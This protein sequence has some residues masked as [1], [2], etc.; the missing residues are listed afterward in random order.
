M[1]FCKPEYNGYGNPSSFGMS[2]AV[3]TVFLTYEFKV[4]GCFLGLTWSLLVTLSALSSGYNSINQLLFGY[5]LGVWLAC[6]IIYAVDY[7]K[8][9]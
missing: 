2:A 6:T 7:D 9:V 8:R 1:F 4:K 5:T 3:C